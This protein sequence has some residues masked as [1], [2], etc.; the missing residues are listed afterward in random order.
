MDVNM[1]HTAGLLDLRRSTTVRRND[2]ERKGKIEY[3]SADYE[4]V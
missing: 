2:T 1:L 4:P 3:V